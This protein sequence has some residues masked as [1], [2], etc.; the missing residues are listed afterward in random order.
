MEVMGNLRSPCEISLACQHEAIL[1]ALY[2]RGLGS[3]DPAPSRTAESVI[4]LLRV[5]CA[6]I[7]QA[8]ECLYSGG[9]WYEAMLLDVP[10]RLKAAEA[11]V[12]RGSV[13]TLANSSY[14]RRWRERRLAG[15]RGR[16]LATAGIPP[17][18]WRARPPSS[19][20]SAHPTETHWVAIVGSRRPSA[21]AARFVGLAAEDA[22]RAGFG[23]VSG[24]APGCDMVALRCASGLHAPSRAILPCALN[25][26]FAGPARSVCE[27]WSG[28]ASSERFSAALALGRNGLIA[29]MSEALLVGQARF[30]MGGSW[31]ASVQALKIGVPVAVYSGPG[32]DPDSWLAA[33]ALSALGARSVVS[34]AEWEHWLWEHGLPV[35]GQTKGPARKVQECRQI[36]A[37]SRREKPMGKSLAGTA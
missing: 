7:S 25:D 8:A 5:A 4:G 15:L 20:A 14:P 3:D 30:R 13:I 19:P 31:S 9:Y 37:Q 16:G 33:E 35:S 23:V 17:A 27:C 26:S 11:L 10:G 18:W 24:G 28:S 36:Y 22:A 2:L 21:K 6:S 1:A 34:L 29:A 12:E 32:L